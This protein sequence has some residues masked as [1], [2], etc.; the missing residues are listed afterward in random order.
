MFNY[1][2]LIPVLVIICVIIYVRSK[3]PLKALV[4]FAIMI[5]PWQGGYWIEA[6]EHDIQLPIVLYLFIFIMSLFEKNQRPFFKRFYFPVLFL[7]TAM[8]FGALMGSA[9]ALHKPSAYA[10]VFSFVNRYLMFY[11]VYNCLRKPGDVKYI[12]WGLLLGAGF[13]GLLATVQ[14]RFWGFRVGIIDIQRSHM[15]WRSSGTFMHPNTLGVYIATIIP[16]IFRMT[17]V[18]YKEKSRYVKNLCLLVLIVGFAGLIFSQNRGSWIALSIAMTAFV[19]LEFFTNI[20]KVRKYLGKFLLPLIILGVIGL[21]LFGDVIYSRLFE[22]SLT[23]DNQ[24][25]EVLVEESKQLIRNY[26]WFGV[27]YFNYMEHVSNIFV[28]NLYYL[29]MAEYGYWG[30]VCFILLMLNWLVNVV[31]GWLSRNYLVRNLCLGLGVSLITFLIASI[32]NPDYHQVHPRLGN[33]IWILIAFAAAINDVARK[34]DSRIIFRLFKE[35]RIDESKK[36]LYMK[37]LRDQWLKVVIR[38]RPNK[39]LKD[40]INKKTDE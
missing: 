26:P 20:G 30:F 22:R 27:G 1:P 23:G 5:T 14:Y 11:C 36:K 25:R 3:E 33:H 13:Q 32:P 28:H 16:L 19:L 29:I 7:A 15:L 10:G 21:F 17:L 40:G 38:D 31:R 6:I 37:Q 9:T 2:V 8:F 24:A 18:A 39:K 35:G 34:Y 12:I 4:T